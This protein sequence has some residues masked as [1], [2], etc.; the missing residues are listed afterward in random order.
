MASSR[1]AMVC[2]SDHYGSVVGILWSV[3][4]LMWSPDCDWW[5][6]T[7]YFVTSFNVFG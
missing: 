6:I 7:V 5:D 3:V 4:E 2:S 1:V